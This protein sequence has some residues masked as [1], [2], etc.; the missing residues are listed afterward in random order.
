MYSGGFKT[1]VWP[2]D[3]QIA[4]QEV[5]YCKNLRKFCLKLILKSSHEHFLSFPTPNSTVFSNYDVS[6][7]FCKTGIKAFVL[8]SASVFF[9]CTELPKCWYQNNSCRP[10]C[11]FSIFSSSA[12]MYLQLKFSKESKLPR[13]SDL[14]PFLQHLNFI[15]E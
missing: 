1:R 10:V 14:F 5:D 8:N 13:K 4:G 12:I 6:I 7:R 15:G 9:L 3:V 2:T 11:R